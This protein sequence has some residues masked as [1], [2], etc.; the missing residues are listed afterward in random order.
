MSERAQIQ[1]RLFEYLSEKSYF[2]APY[3]VLEG[4]HAVGR[5]KIRTV[6]FGVS[7][8]LDAVIE[9]WSPK[10][11]VVKCQGGLGYKFEGEYDSVDKLIERFTK[12]T[13]ETT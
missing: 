11:L 7:R 10:K 5:G 1:E 4:I 13:P 6:T 9:I 3:G 12:E 2:D 8:Y